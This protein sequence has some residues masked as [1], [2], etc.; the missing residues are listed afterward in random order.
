MLHPRTIAQ[1]LWA[2]P[3]YAVAYFA[4]G[5]TFS[6]LR[7]TN[8]L[9]YSVLMMPLGILLVIAAF[10]IWISL[11]TL[12]GRHTPVATLRHIPFGELRLRADEILPAA[13]GLTVAWPALLYIAPLVATFPSPSQIYVIQIPGIFSGLFVAWAIWNWPVSRAM[14]IYQVLTPILL[15]LA[16]SL[17]VAVAGDDLYITIVARALGLFYF[18]WLFITPLWL[19]SLMRQ[20]STLAEQAQ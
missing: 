15:V 19:A 17:Q 8:P 1:L 13:A 9:F 16:A 4:M 5:A 18:A 11:R 7:D 12:T 6:G 2:G 14:K 10:G 20:Q 3:V